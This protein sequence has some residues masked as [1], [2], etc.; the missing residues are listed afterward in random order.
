MPFVP[1][2][3]ASTPASASAF[4]RDA[5]ALRYRFNR[6]GPE[7]VNQDFI[8][9]EIAGRMDERLNYL[10]LAPQWI[11]DLGC[12]GGRD[13]FQLQKRYPDAHCLGLDFAEQLLNFSSQRPR[14][15]RFG[16]PFELRQ[17]LKTH[18]VCA[19]AQALPI[20]A[21]AMN[22]VWSN[23]LLPWVHDLRA[24]VEQVQRVL[25]EEGVWMFSTLGPDTLKELRECFPNAGENH[26]H[27]FWDMHDIGDMLVQAGFSDPVLDMEMLHLQYTD[28]ETLL[29]DL[30]RSVATNALPTRLKGLTGKT[31]WQ[32]VKSQLTR[33]V[34]GESLPVTL[35]IIQGHAW[36]GR[37]ARPGGEA[38]VIQFYPSRAR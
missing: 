10:N 29:A 1:P 11:L 28:A 2:L 34:R 19:D 8:A 25:S 27:G 21:G 4:L 35:E 3:S 18:S 12:G 17:S 6:A 20:S 14:R 23:L 7:Q 36:K 22:L 31:F 5:P 16:W 24:V 13:L 37:S 30:K 15:R 38:Q 9:Q 26:L 33:S 32:G